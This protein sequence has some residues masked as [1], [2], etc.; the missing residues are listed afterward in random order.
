MSSFSV[1]HLVLVTQPILEYFISPV[2]LPYRKLKPSFAA[3][4]QRQLLVRSLKQSWYEFHLVM[5][6]QSNQI[7]VAY[8]HK[9][10]AT[11]ALAYLVD[12]TP[13]YRKEFAAVLVFTL[14][15]WWRKEYL[16]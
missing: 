7:L 15:L 11:V 16:Q 6:L 5:T 13:L 8:S 14:L 9:L 1:D 3:G 4:Y 12:R 2:R 10:F